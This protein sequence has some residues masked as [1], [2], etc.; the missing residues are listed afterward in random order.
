MRNRLWFSILIIMALACFPAFVHGEEAAS[1]P[2]ACWITGDRVN[3]RTMP[4]RDAK[5]M[6]LLGK[7]EEVAL[8]EAGEGWTRVRSSRLG[9]GWVANAYICL[10][11]PESVSRGDYGRVNE[12]LAYAKRWLGVP[13]R[14]G[15]STPHAFDCSGFTAYVFKNF[16]YSLPHSSVGQ[17]QLGTV[18]TR[19]QL[20]PG[21]LVFF[22]TVGDRI[23]HVG[24]YL[25]DGLF[26]HASSGSGQV[27]ITPL[28]KGYYQKRYVCARRYLQPTGVLP[29]R[30]RTL[31]LVTTERVE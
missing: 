18:V 11:R 26:I 25:G 22:N 17:A 16:G 9:E 14:Y 12:L 21:D 5:S 7:G 24:I 19:D 2:A 10:A 15:G 13:Y 27:T 4:S 20:L 28:N 1:S 23:S 6:G 8:L 31:E 29:E 30:E 3:L